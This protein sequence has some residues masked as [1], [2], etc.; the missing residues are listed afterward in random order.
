MARAVALRP[1]TITRPRHRPRCAERKRH[2]F[3]TWK[4]YDEKSPLV[5]AALLGPV[6][7]D[8]RMTAGRAANWRRSTARP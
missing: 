6:K 4:H 1:R 2:S 3:T 8:W 7:I 5:P